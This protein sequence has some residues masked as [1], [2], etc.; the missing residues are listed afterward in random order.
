MKAREELK[1][2]VIVAVFQREDELR[3]LLDSLCLQTDTDFELLI[4]DDGSPEPLE[5]IT[6]P[7][8]DR[9]NLHYFYKPN[10]GSG[11]TRNYGMAKAKGNY[12]IF[13]DSDT[14][15]PPSYIQ[16][17]KAELAR[18]YTDGF[19]GPDAADDSFTDL[20]KAITFSMT[21]VLTTGGIRG[22]KT[23]VGRFEPRSFNMGISREVYEKTGG[24]SELRAGED[25]DLT[26]RIW[27]SGFQTRLFPEAKV[28]HKRRTSLKKFAKQ[29]HRFGSARPIL[30]LR[31]PEHARITYWFPGVFLC[32]LCFSLVMAAFSFPLREIRI[33]SCY[34]SSLFFSLFLMAYV[35]YFVS[36]F[37]LCVW[38]YRSVK[39]G[40]LSLLT[41]LVQFS[42]YGYGFLKSQFY[43]KILRRTPQQAYPK[44]FDYT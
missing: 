38:Q 37:V 12:F 34:V 10:S 26:F 33:G 42:G 44:Y 43:F 29:T 9:L 4:V 17:V 25:P 23:H 39:V 11:K 19:G 20:Q 27:K 8:A 14:I 30:N 3:E 36:L 15:I 32:G 6:K 41:T 18:E 40:L 13:L 2:S 24:F 16:T 28:Y 7:Y 21:S 5:S 22:G 35:L 1:L 31:H